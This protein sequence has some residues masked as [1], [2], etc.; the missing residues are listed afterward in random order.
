MTLECDC[1]GREYT[2]A[3]HDITLRIP[4]GAVPDNRRIHFE[5]GVAL[6]GPFIFPHNTQPISPILWLCILEEDVVLKQP[7]QVI[8]PHFLAEDKLCYHQAGFAKASHND[9]TFQDNGQM[10][11]S[12]LPCG[13]KPQFVFSGCRGYGILS[14]NHC[15]FYCIHAN[16]SRE[17]A[18]DAGYCLVRIEATPMPY[19]NVIIFSAIYFLDSCLKVQSI[20]CMD[21]IYNVLHSL[22]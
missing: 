7:F 19:R 5:F 8:L 13:I 6:Y 11:Y 21:E 1:N 18:M 9:V 3:E 14:L 20:T 10:C 22:L 15:C 12:F 17:L 16:Q 4:K 2:N